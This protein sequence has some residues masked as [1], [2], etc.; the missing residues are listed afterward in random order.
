MD[1]LTPKAKK[2]VVTIGLLFVIVIIGL[3][4]SLSAN[5]PASEI[6]N[7]VQEKQKIMFFEYGEKLKDNNVFTISEGDIKM[8]I[9]INDLNTMKI[10]E[11]EYIAIDDKNVNHKIMVSVKDTQFPVIK[12]KDN[13]EIKLGDIIDINKELKANDPVDGELDLIFDLPKLDEAKEYKV[14]VLAK[15]ANDNETIKNI[16]IKVKDSPVVDNKLESENETSKPV[17]DNKPASNNETSK[18]KVDNKPKPDVT[19]QP[20]I[21]PEIEPQP[22]IEPVELIA[23]SN[24]KQ[25]TDMINAINRDRIN[26]GLNPLTVSEEL[27]RAASVRTLE[28]LESFSHTRPDGSS[29]S[30]V[31]NQVYGENIAYGSRDG[32]ITHERFMNSPGHKNNILNQRWNIVGIAQ[33]VPEGMPAFWTVLFGE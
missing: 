14:K 3:T 31:S 8:I 26:I 25:I 13:F 9:T 32:N 33:V 10:G 20:T 7:P 27:S 11:T 24:S 1:N 19:P 4:R 5:K 2:I 21:Q 28:L 16:T 23:T 6:L 12:G 18:P 30:T 29:F 17:A 15:D 22:S